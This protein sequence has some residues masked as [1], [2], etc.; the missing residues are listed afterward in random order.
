MN[1][2]EI[3]LHLGCGKRYIPGFCH[4]DIRKFP[5]IDYVASIDKLDM[6]EDDSV[7]LVYA[8]HLLEHFQR[9]KIEEVLREWYRVLKKRRNCSF[10]GS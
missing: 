9:D 6:F 4:I 10:G 2:Q 3:K 8:S 1:N 7:D 5:H